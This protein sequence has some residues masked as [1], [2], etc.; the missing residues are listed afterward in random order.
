VRA[1]GEQQRV[2]GVEARE[3]RD[4]Q[5]VVGNV[6]VTCRDL[7][8]QRRLERLNRNFVSLLSHKLRT[9]LTSLQCALQ[10][11]ESAPAEEHPTLLAEMNLRMHDL[12]VL[13]DRLFDFTDLID[14]DGH[15]RGRG[16]LERAR[17]EVAAHLAW[18]PDA[19]RAQIVWEIA[20]D[21]CDVPVPTNRLRAVLL[22]LIDNAIKFTGEER[23]WVR[24]AARR[25]PHSVCIDVED[26]GPGIPKADQ[27]SVLEAF[28]QLD[29]DFT[30]NVPGAGLGIAMVREI[31]RRAGGSLRLADAEPHGCIFTVELPQAPPGGHA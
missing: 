16:N 29:D 22:N 2:L 18:R 4:E 12:G 13:I 8:R 9:P 27:A 30:G 31:A 21:A 5:G 23:P 28:R 20:P 19:V 17:A 24:V 26:R 15:K 1:D 3:L 7:T 14:G 10:L 6:V 11:L 25:T